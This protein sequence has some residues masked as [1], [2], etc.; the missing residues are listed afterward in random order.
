MIEDRMWLHAD[1]LGEPCETIADLLFRLPEQ[2]LR[3]QLESYRRKWEL[4]HGPTDLTKYYTSMR[5]PDEQRLL[6]RLSAKLYFDGLPGFA[7]AYVY[8]QMVEA[9]RDGKL[10]VMPPGYVELFLRGDMQPDRA[11]RAP[12]R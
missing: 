6:F 7:R 11:D 3:D 9:Q 5:P 4:A 2:G 8:E 1:G 12:R 10:E